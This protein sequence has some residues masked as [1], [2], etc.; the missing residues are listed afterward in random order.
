MIVVDRRRRRAPRTADAPPYAAGHFADPEV[1]GVQSLVRIYN[2]HRLLTWIQDVE[3]SVYGYLFQAGRNGWGTAGMGGNGQFNRL[4]AL[5]DVADGRGP[6]RDRLTED[7]DLGLRLIARRLEGPPGAARR[8]STSRGSRSSAAAVPPAHPLVAGQPAGDRRC[9]REVLRAP[10]SASAPRFELLA[11]LLM[12]FWQGIIGVAPGRR[13]GASRSPGWRRSGAAGRPGSSASSTCSPSAARCSAAIASRARDGLRS[14][15]CVGFLIGQVYTL[16]TW[17]IWPVLL[18]ST[19][20]PAD[21]A[22]RLGEDRARAADRGRRRSRRRP[23]SRRSGLGSVARR[24]PD[25]EHR[26]RLQR[27]PRPERPARDACA[28]RAR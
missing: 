4:S 6:W 17:F 28:G 27:Q 18:R 5:D 25:P 11:Y 24:A 1:G 19:A 20:A 2:R 7:Q 9:A 13:G 22:R 15:G 14:A 16:Y 21:R 12:P 23:E 3:F 26:Q 8:R 10:V